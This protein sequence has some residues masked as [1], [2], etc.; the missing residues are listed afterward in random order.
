MNE[1]ISLIDVVDMLLRRWWMILVSAIAVGII[2]FTYTEVFIDPTYEST[3][4]LY[5]NSTAQTSVS[6]E[7]S[8]GTLAASQKLVSTYAEIL[9][10]RTFLEQV[11][12]D[13]DNEYTV[14]E[15]K[16][17][18]RMEAVN[19]TEILE[20]KKDDAPKEIKSQLNQK[21]QQTA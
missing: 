21:Q 19:E 7:I 8:S 1:Q 9:Q 18:L 12:K 2:V 6:G 20:I 3:G 14:N 4:A 13:L 5:V 10:R 15:I 11:V 16:S 17:M